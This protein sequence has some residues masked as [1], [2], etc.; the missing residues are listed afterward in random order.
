MR[1]SIV[2][3][4]MSF[5]EWDIDVPA[6]PRPGDHIQIWSHDDKIKTLNFTVTGI[7]FIGKMSGEGEGLSKL[8]V[9]VHCDMR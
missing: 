8:G 7:M 3:S 5:S 4:P 2:R 1:V 6:L 9:L